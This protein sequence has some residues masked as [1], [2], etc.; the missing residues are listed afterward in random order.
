MAQSNATSNHSHWWERLRRIWLGNAQPLLT[1]VAGLTAA[2]AL[3]LWTAQLVDRDVSM[4]FQRLSERPI[5][6]IRHRLSLYSYGLHGMRGLFAA[7]QNQVSPADL[8]A[9]AQSR[10]LSE[11]FPGV[12]GWGFA[13]YVRP[14]ELPRLLD[15]LA[16]QGQ[17]LH[18][19]RLDGL[20]LPPPRAEAFV[21]TMIEPMHQN[22]SALG[23]DLAS[24]SRRRGA[25]LLARDRGEAVLSAPLRL[26]QDKTQLSLL[27]MLPVYRR[28]GIPPTLAERRAEIVGWV[29]A[30]LRLHMVLGFLQ[31]EPELSH[32]LDIKLS[33]INL[34]PAETLFH[35]RPPRQARG[36]ADSLNPWLWLSPRLSRSTTL[37]VGGRE[38]LIEISATDSLYTGIDRSLPW[39][40]LLLG[41]LASILVASLLWFYARLRREAEDR[42]FEMTT[43]LRE[44]ESLLKSTLA[45]LDDWVFVFDSKGVII[46]CHEPSRPHHWRPRW[47]FLGHR[48]DDL[49]LPPAALEQLQQAAE[50]V[51]V[52]GKAFCDFALPLEGIATVFNARLIARQD[53]E[54]RFAGITMVARDIS[55]ERQ[56]A[57]ALH[58]S[59]EK[60]RL[61]FAEAAEPIVLIKDGRYL[62][63]NPAALTLFRSAR[64]HLL[65]RPVG[66]FSA[67][68][69]EGG[70]PPQQRLIGLMTETI[71]H[72]PQH[73]EWAFQRQDTG[74]T[75]PA[76]IHMSCLELGGEPHFLAVIS[77]LVA[78]KQTEAALIAARDAAETATRDKSDFLATMSHEIRTPM[79]G[80]LGMA[81]LLMNTALNAE[82]ADYVRTL[83]QSGQG[84]LTIINDI[85]DFSKI[86][87]G[88]LTF[89][90][91]P[92]DLQS[93]VE[94]TCE[95]LLP[96]I[97]AKGLRLDI[98]LDPDTP[99]RVVGDPGRLR[100]VL[101]NYLSNAVKFTEAGLVRVEIRPLARGVQDSLI[102]LT[103]SDSGIGIAPDKL[104]SLFQRFSQADASTTR[105]FGGTGLGL[106]ITKALVE[107][108]GGE[109]GVS[110][111]LGQGSSFRASFRLQLD[112]RPE[113]RVQLSPALQG[114]RVLLI[115]D[116][117]SNRLVVRAGLQHQ[118][119]EV[120]EAASVAAA[121]AS[122]QAQRPA[123]IL[124][125]AELPDGNLENLVAALRA[126]AP[127]AHIPLL[128]LSSRPEYSDH[129][130]CR[131]LGL[132]AYLPKPTRLHW[133][134]QAFNRLQDPLLPGELITRQALSE[135]AAHQRAST[136]LAPL[137]QGLRVLLAEDN[138]VNQKVAVRMLEKLGCQVD[139]VGN[140]L[141]AV[142]MAAQLPYDLLLMDL[143]MPEMDGLAASRALRAQGLTTLPIIALTANSQEADRRLCLAAGMNDFLA[144]PIRLEGLHACLQ[145]WTSH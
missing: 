39:L 101:L 103:V 133:L 61:L 7:G 82:Q 94:E 3:S 138:P 111:T 113:S 71:L 140:G 25:A 59:E 46:D 63:A 114:A 12:T 112:L 19:Q 117:D 74:E 90:S 132:A 37:T 139:A 144:K 36:L 4:R 48:L 51:L 14:G 72:G 106:A 102:E 92:F 20:L 28:P 110:S 126:A 137:R 127:L 42:A 97:R 53:S 35:L 79:N 134:L 47:A 100:Q 116:V 109:V 98:A 2:L 34:Y 95:L 45:S 143:Q 67:L 29:S 68:P 104:G 73:F 69:Q 22:Q 62:D 31:D 49:E 84:L 38:L 27:Y 23:L 54:G 81:Q 52:T 108:M 33:D 43:S 141:E 93:A 130:L 41:T 66:S 40:T 56:Q 44:R 16:G 105:R 58:E 30:P 6:L 15:R 128:L 80:V 8:Q 145:R 5:D 96:Q 26:V 91:I 89:E 13:E 77:D 83:Y 78:R 11:E 18:Y 129:A 115:D 118:G 17:P 55:L 124:L 86:E 76:E 32:H 122:L 107:C 65:G 136:E 121:A 10:R 123:F 70:E 135:W 87:A 64:E 60:F 21:L 142:A 131:R 120:V 85:L 24:E 57:Q 125:D 99:F 9:Y 50:Q 75:F 1:L 88:R 119:L